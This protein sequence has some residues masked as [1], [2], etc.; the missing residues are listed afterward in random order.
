VQTAST[1]EGRLED[2]SRKPSMRFGILCEG[3]FLFSWQARCLE[4]LLRLENTQLV[5]IATLEHS[6]EENTLRGSRTA[7]LRHLF[8]YSYARYLF[9]ANATRRVNVQTSFPTT[10]LLT[11]KTVRAGGEKLK[12]LVAEDLNAIHRYNLDFL[13]YFGSSEFHGAILDVPRY[14]VWS[15]QHG[16]PEKCR[17]NPPGFWEIFNADCVTGASLQKLTRRSETGVILRKG[18]VRT[19]DYSYARNLDAIC[20]E[21]ARWAKQVCVDIGN[22]VAT[23]L[24]SGSPQLRLGPSPVPTNTQ[25]F[26]F[27]VTMMLNR[28]RKE[29]RQLFRHDRW[30]IGILDAPIHKLLEGGVRPPLRY[31]PG[32]PKHKFGADPFACRKNGSLAIL[33]EDYDYRRREGTIAGFEFDGQD[34]LPLSLSGLELSTHMSYPYLFEYQGDIYCL[35]DSSRLRKLNLYKMERF[36]DQWRKVC[37]LLEP[38]G[39]LDAT[40]FQY[41]GRWWLTCVESAGLNNCCNL[42]VWYALNLFGPW[43]SHAVNPVKTDVRSARPGGTPFFYNGELFR[44]AQDCSRTY[45]GR[46]V[47]NRI[48]R[49]TPA[50]FEE[51]PVAFVEPEPQSPF[52]NGLHTLSAAGSVTVVDAK[53]FVSDASTFRHS[54]FALFRAMGIK[55]RGVRRGST[56]YT[57]AGLS[58]RGHLL[59]DCRSDSATAIPGEEKGVR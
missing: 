48:K 25:V 31:L 2:N 38:F 59:A 22:G 49:L 30:N 51:E 10:P 53:R 26:R 37:T 58:V 27:I 17:G 35:P 20:S 50:E 18:F 6:K 43:I 29:W 13:L 42:C 19:V 40:I 9:R 32:L 3:P 12:S 39:G 8:F 1:V 23:Y 54:L 5:L 28:L 56:R 45:G 4:E 36:P 47:I 55:L 15:F 14:G 34:F 41:E 57:H 46:V 52:P 7:R 11:C 44:P 33:Y 16:D 24:D 21:A